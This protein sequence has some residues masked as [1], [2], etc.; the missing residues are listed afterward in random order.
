MPNRFEH[1]KI[2]D[3]IAVC[4]TA[5]KIQPVRRS[6]TNNSAPFCLAADV[7]AGDLSHP[8]TVTR[9]QLRSNNRQW[10]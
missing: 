7:L 2:G 1:R 10:H 4:E 9:L 8:R 6:Q 3:A 5:R